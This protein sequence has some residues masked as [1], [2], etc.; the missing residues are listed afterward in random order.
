MVG[1]GQSA[2]KDRVKVSVSVLLQA[3]VTVRTYV[4]VAVTIAVQV[5][6]VLTVCPPTVQRYVNGAVEVTSAV[7]G[8]APAAT[9]WSTG[10][11]CQTGVGHGS[12]V[13]VKVSVSGWWQA[14]VTVTEKVVD[15][16]VTPA[17]VRE[18][19]G[20]QRK[21]LD[22]GNHRTRPQPRTLVFQD[23][24]ASESR[25]VRVD[26]VGQLGCPKCLDQLCGRLPVARVILGIGGEI[27]PVK[28]R[29][30]ER[31]RT[32]R[33]EVDVVVPSAKIDLTTYHEPKIRRPSAGQARAPRADALP[34]PKGSSPEGGG[35][36]DGSSTRPS[37]RI[38]RALGKIASAGARS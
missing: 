8:T 18:L 12:T 36:V 27:P 33:H 20:F 10:S 37:P 30:A 15:E 21:L 25:S 7:N 26:D 38:A 17:A 22:R 3:S 35:A 5:A 4:V 23:P 34:A 32:C 16:R 29:R 1:A 31:A 19:P 9:C 2:C 13:S 14:S 11:V 24:R 28:D 6:S